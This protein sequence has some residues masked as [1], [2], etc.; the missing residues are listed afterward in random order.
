M[1]YDLHVHSRYSYDG[2]LSPEEIVKIAIKKGLNG[3]AITD[4]NTIRGSQEAKN[5]ETKDFRIIII[6]NL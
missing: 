1:K 3:I 2:I 4:H 5:Y 6:R